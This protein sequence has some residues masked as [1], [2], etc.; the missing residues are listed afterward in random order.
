MT[1]TILIL[2]VCSTVI[3]SVV[4]AMKP[5]FKKFSG[6]YTV[7]VCTFISFLL[8]VLASFSVAPYLWYELNDGVLTLIWLALGTGSNLIYDIRELVKSASDKIRGVVSWE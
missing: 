8:G 6:K 3:T 1:T 2:L 4:N 5:A 7:T